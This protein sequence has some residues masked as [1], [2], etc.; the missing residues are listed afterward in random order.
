MKGR[1]LFNSI[2]KMLSNERGM[3]GVEETDGDE[4]AAQAYEEI[5]AE[6]EGREPKDLS[7]P[8]KEDKEPEPKPG[9][10]EVELSGAPEKKPEEEKKPED[11]QPEDDDSKPEKEEELDPETGK[12]KEKDRDEEITAHAEKHEM[13]YAEAKEDIEKTEKI[14]EQFKNDPKE[15]AKAM[16]NKDREY[17]KL[18]NEAEKNKVPEEK[19]KT[20]RKLTE[21]QFR[22]HV[23]A[24]I[25]KDPDKYLEAYQKR[26]PAKS[27]EMS[28]EAIIEEVMDLEWD[29]YSQYS[30]NQEKVLSEKAAKT[31][32]EFLSGFK[33]TDRKFLPEVKVL[34]SGLNDSDIIAEDFDPQYLVD[35]AKG[36]NYD[37]DIKAAEERGFKRGK[38]D[39][40]ILGV[41]GAG[42]GS[43]PKSPGG[44]KGG[45]LSQDQKDR[46]EE[47]FPLDDGYPPEKAWSL[48]Q[49]TYEDELKANPKF[50]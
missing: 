30:T 24:L 17:D 19:P 32:D 46:A 21:E 9:E 6:R 39:T 12:P 5:E 8:E 29:G 2:F 25:E 37:A 31:R 47:M 20:F 18:K 42:G 50:V 16:R 38:E 26:Y 43:K 49:E 1:L 36:K 27:S 48:F 44:S 28:T 45:A 3:A 15:M 35:L 40:E 22:H 10:P 7:K 11:D 13:T 41:K 33:D 14:I 4:L 23:K 34:L